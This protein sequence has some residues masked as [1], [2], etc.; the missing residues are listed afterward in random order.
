MRRRVGSA[1][2]S[3]VV[4]MTAIITCKIYELQGIK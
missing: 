1:S 2:T 4:A 3:N